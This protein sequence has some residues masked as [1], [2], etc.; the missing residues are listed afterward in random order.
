MKGKIHIRSSHVSMKGF[1]F[2]KGFTQVVHMYLWPDSYVG[3]D[4][5][6]EFTCIYGGIHIRSSHISMEGFIYREEFI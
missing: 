3:R 5:Y 4:S 2:R 1:T 6:K